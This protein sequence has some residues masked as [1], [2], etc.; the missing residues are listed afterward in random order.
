MGEKRRNSEWNG[1]RWR[2]VWT[3]EGQTRRPEVRLG[4]EPLAWEVRIAGAISNAHNTHTVRY[5]DP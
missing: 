1:V 5:E 3:M 4:I 2:T